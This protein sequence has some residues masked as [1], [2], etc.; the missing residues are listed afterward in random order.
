M[1]PKAINDFRRENGVGPVEVWNDV[2]SENCFKHT[3]AMI[4]RGEL[5][6]APSYYLEDY[7]EA[8]GGYPALDSEENTLRSLIFVTFAQK[9]KHRDLLL[10]AN[11]MGFGYIFNEHGL[12]MTI[13]GR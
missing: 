11:E 2:L 5:Y 10:N 7:G 13:R 8:V 3:Q 6:H 1:I 12:I 9:P 4:Q